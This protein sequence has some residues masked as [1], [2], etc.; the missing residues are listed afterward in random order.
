MKHSLLLVAVVAL[1]AVAA[2]AHSQY[3]YLDTNNDGICD[4]NDVLSPS[5]TSVDVWLDT[6]SNGDGSPATCQ[7][8]AANLTI[9]SYEVFVRSTGAVTLGAW[10]DNMS[11]ATNFG[12]FTGGTDAY[13]GRG[14]GTV[15]SPGT[16][17]LGSLAISGVFSILLVVSRTPGLKELIPVADFFRVALVVHVGREVG[18]RPWGD[19]ARGVLSFWVIPFLIAGLVLFGWARGARVYE[20]FVE[21][22]KEGF[23]VAL[24]IIPYLVAILVAVAM[25]RASGCLDLF[26]AAV[27]PLTAP[28]GL[29]AEAVPMA[30][31]RPLSGSGAFGVMSEILSTHGPD[32]Y[33]G[34][35]VSTMQGS[36][37]TTFYVLAVYFGAVGVKKTRH[38]VPAGL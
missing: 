3:M 30:I 26:V 31:L 16:Y 22:A 32:S 17:K 7:Q 33:L 27:S 38:A 2:P 14:S 13:H 10:T 6:D 18:V 23:Q 35:L 8:S 34:Y 25:F 21:G 5:S 11:F 15:L 20:S 36:T 12:D 19:V 28:L 9:N 37:D 29:P 24:R 4:S 1:V